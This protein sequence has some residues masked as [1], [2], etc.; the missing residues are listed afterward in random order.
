VVCS[1][2]VELRASVCGNPIKNHGIMKFGWKITE[3]NLLLEAGL[4]SMLD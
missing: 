3:A 1:V 2:N 4:W